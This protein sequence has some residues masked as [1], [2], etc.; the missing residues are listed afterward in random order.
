MQKQLGTKCAEK[1]RQRLMELKAADALSDMS[2]LPPTRFH[3]LS[4]NRT[5]QFSIDLEH[6]Y[7]LLLIPANEPIRVH[8]D[9][10]IDRKRVTEIEVIEIVDTH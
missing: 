6:P 8:D 10:G 5:G 3:E 9:G 4:G 1:L 7:R 2:H